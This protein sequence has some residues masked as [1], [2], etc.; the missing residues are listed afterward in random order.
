M[1]FKG[2]EKKTIE[3]LDDWRGAVKHCAKNAI[4]HLEKAWSI[5]NID[6]EMVVFRGITA[7]EEAAS[8][9]FYSLKNHQYNN[10]DRILFQQHTY[11]LG[12]FPFLR[13]VGK[14]L[15]DNLQ[16]ETWPFDRRFQLRHTEKEGRK[17]IELLLAIPSVGVVQPIP[18]PN[19]SVSLKD[20]G[21][22]Y[23]FETDFQS[24][25]EGQNYVTMLKYVKDLAAERNRLLYANSTGHPVV[26]G[27]MEGY[28][29]NQKRKV[30][31]ILTVMLMIDPWEKVEGKSAFVQQGLDSFLSL[32]ERISGEEV[33]QPSRW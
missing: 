3:A 18:P 29:L 5:R 27:D 9:L 17:A 7:E 10:A 12:L 8:S 15:G 21:R 28:L 14:F 23:T 32:L 22:T 30:M 31:A 1:E 4:A 25:I 6:M 24:I 26:T 13:A 19:F 20:T 2:F 11:K 33:F 16:Q